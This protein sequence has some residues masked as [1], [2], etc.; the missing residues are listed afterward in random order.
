MTNIIEDLL[1]WRDEILDIA[2]GTD[3]AQVAAAYLYCA[4]SI[5]AFIRKYQ[6]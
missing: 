3:D 1:E 2:W 4:S 5:T 6:S